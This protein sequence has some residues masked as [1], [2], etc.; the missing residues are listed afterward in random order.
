MKSIQAE[1]LLEYQAL[2]QPTA[3]DLKHLFILP[4]AFMHQ[5]HC[6]KKETKFRFFLMPIS[7]VTYIHTV[8]VIVFFA[9]NLSS[10]RK[11]IKSTC[12]PII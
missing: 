3:Q 9:S 12:E 1:F 8:G 6:Q 2:K 10:L 4:Q 7:H 5:A 11:K